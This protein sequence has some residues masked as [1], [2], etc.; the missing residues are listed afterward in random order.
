MFEGFAAELL[1]ALVVVSLAN[2]AFMAKMQ[3]DVSTLKTQVKPLWKQYVSRQTNNPGRT[4][5]G[6]ECPDMEDRP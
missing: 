3:R 1:A 5:G 2:L 6:V 4:D